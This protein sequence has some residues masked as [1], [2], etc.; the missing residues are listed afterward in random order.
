MD[1][2]GCHGNLRTDLLSKLKYYV[3]HHPSIK[4][5]AHPQ[6]LSALCKLRV[7]IY[8]RSLL[9]SVCVASAR[10]S[11]KQEFKEELDRVQ[12][13]T[14]LYDTEAA[15]SILSG[16]NSIILFLITHWKKNII[17]STIWVSDRRRRE[18]DRLIRQ[19]LH[20]L[21]SFSCK[22]DWSR[23]KSDKTILH[24]WTQMINLANYSFCH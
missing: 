1:L 5:H 10:K 19:A 15:G 13:I 4:A 24:S 3:Y 12:Y 14:L 18:Q 2:S 23:P 9:G 6:G 17:R 21:T 20:Q 7:S 8:P 11:E 22:A 16:G